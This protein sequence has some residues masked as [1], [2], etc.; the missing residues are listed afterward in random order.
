MH[1]SDVT[2]VLKRCCKQIRRF[3]FDLLNKSKSICIIADEWTDITSKEYCSV[4]AR[5][6][7]DN[8]DYGVVFL[9]FFRLG[10]IRAETVTAAIVNA[11]SEF[12]DKVDLRKKLLHK[13]MM[14]Q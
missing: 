7:M 12:K 2:F 8:L 5:Y 3:Q 13:H 14:E 9:G 1:H 6:V 11:F 4:S 10:N